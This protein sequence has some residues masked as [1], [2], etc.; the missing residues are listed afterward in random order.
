MNLAVRR[1]ILFFFSI[2]TLAACEDPTEIGLNLQDDNQIGAEF[3]DTLTVNTGTVLLSDSI[4]SFRQENALVGFM[5]DPFLGTV[6][7]SYFT[8]IGLGGADLKF[9]DAP[10]ADSLILTLDY[11]FLYPKK[12]NTLPITINVHRLTEGFQDKS[13]YFTNS[14]PLAYQSEPIG[15]I[16][17]VP[18]IERHKLKNGTLADSARLIRIKLP[19][20][21]A[22]EIVEQSGKAPLAS[23][24]NFSK[25]L[26]G[27][28]FVV[29]GNTPAAIVGITTFPNSVI[30][31]NQTGLT[32]YFKN[33]TEAKT[34]S[35]SLNG[36]AVKN[37]SRVIAN[38]TGTALA[39]IQEHQYIPSNETNGVT[40]IQAG[41]QL[42]TKLTIPHLKKLKEKHGEIVL[43]RAE[44]IVPV[45]S[46]T[47]SHNDTIFLSFAPPTQLALYE[48]NSTNRILRTADGTAK[49]V[50]M[51]LVNTPN[52][53]NFPAALNYNVKKEH[54][55]VNI[56]SHVQAIL[57]DKKPNNG[58]LLAP[59]NIT[60]SANSGT[61]IV[62]YT[63]PL[64]AIL[65]NTE[66][67]SVKLRVYFSKLN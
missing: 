13:S 31:S 59:V 6:R 5:S 39:G 67:R 44:L 37:Y 30:P 12:S 50:Q 22:K 32:L 58:I 53:Y 20:Q 18:T 19:T 11:N 24:G 26:K 14:Q 45:K 4:L 9:G 15:S 3:T 52:I 23:Q 46:G 43:N 10:V 47:I 7:T 29:E 64:R 56:T 49:T 2:A 48:T 62:P 41:T 57:Q 63:K 17:F 21:L 36:N 55:S 33:G 16:N 65:S 35:F 60:N 54:Y 61:Q 34:H 51:D 66:N 1:F 25:F 40:Y 8:E 28:A 42:L 27:L 38:R